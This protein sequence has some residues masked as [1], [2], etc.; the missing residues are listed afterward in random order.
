M[1]KDELAEK[2]NELL[3]VD[4]EWKKLSLKDLEKIYDALTSE[5]V[6]VL[7]LKLIKGK[8]AKLS[9]K[10]STLMAELGEE[11]GGFFGFGIIPRI[12]KKVISGGEK[13]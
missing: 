10:I 1:R 11:E 4:V 7:A 9:E 12:R 8:T 5:K 3:G 6:V 2:L 13:E